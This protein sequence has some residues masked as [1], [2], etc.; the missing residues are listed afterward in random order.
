M[1]YFEISPSSFQ[2]C[3]C[4]FLFHFTCCSQTQE[5]NRALVF[6][7]GLTTH[8]RKVGIQSFLVT[9]DDWQQQQ[10]FN[11][12]QLWWIWVVVCK[13][14][15]I[16]TDVCL[17]ISS[18]LHLSVRLSVCKHSKKNISYESDSWFSLPSLII[19]H[20]WISNNIHWRIIP[21]QVWIRYSAISV[22]ITE[23]YLHI[24]VRG[25]TLPCI[26][27]NSTAF[28]RNGLNKTETSLRLLSSSKSGLERT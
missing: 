11:R 24:C 18:S 13:T 22:L 14:D 21:S 6:S 3:F 9:Q 10:H 4:C 28:I 19:P 16:S 1:L 15:L 23:Q 7:N 20:A 27:V 8:F 12:K 2:F 25:I 5:G 26:Y 17:S